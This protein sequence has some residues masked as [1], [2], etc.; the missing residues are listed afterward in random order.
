MQKLS[1]NQGSREWLDYRLN[2]VTA[3]DAAPIAKIKGAFN[4]RVDIMADKLGR[5]KDL[6]D[7][8]KRI[9]S[10]GHAWEEAVR[11]AF[12]GYEPAVII[13]E[14]NPRFMASLDGLNESLRMILEIKSVTTREKFNEYCEQVPEHYMAQVQWQL[15]CADYKQAIIAFVHAGEVVARPVTAMPEMQDRLK[16]CAIEFLQELD[17]IKGGTAPSPMQEL[18][19][20]DMDRLAYLKKTEAEMKIQLDM[21]DEEIKS[22]AEKLMKETSA[23]KLESAAISISYMERQGSIDYKKIPEVQKLGE[24][25]LQSFRGKSTKSLQVKLK[26]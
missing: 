11:P 13:S 25:Y 18:S 23:S 8:Q 17:S 12:Q 2:C 26:K 16:A 14:E 10:E 5:V 20:H 1:L 19:S 22:I 21:I 15:M 3:T 4:K 9:F 24:S 6:S 7:Y